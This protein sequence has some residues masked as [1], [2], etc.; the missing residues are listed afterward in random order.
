MGDYG[1]GLGIGAGTI[2][3]IWMLVSVVPLVVQY[4][5]M[6][7]AVKNAVEDVMNRFHPAKETE[8][9]LTDIHKMLKAQQSPVVIEAGRPAAAE[10]RELQAVEQQAEAAANVN[11]AAGEGECRLLPVENPFMYDMG[12]CSACGEVQRIDRLMCYKCEAVFTN[13]GQPLKRS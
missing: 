9:I 5:I 4:F 10:A 2:I 1:R 6:K 11:D 13:G 8:K 3:L 7:A 12:R